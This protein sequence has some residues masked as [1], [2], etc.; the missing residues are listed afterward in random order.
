MTNYAKRESDLPGT[1]IVSS[2]LHK[3]L[4]D[5]FSTVSTAESHVYPSAALLGEFYGAI[6]LVGQNVSDAVDKSLVQTRKFLD[7]LA[8]TSISTMTH[9]SSMGSNLNDVDIKLRYLT[10]MFEA[11]AADNKTLLTE[12]KSLSTQVAKLTARLEEQETALS[13]SNKPQVDFTADTAE[14]KS[15]SGVL[16]ATETEIIPAIS[17][18]DPD[19]QPLIV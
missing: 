8:A 12:V 16:V 14:S 19:T 1:D 2:E 3:L 13:E 17:N 6:R 11:S 18:D 9:I 5:F 4:N 15:T 10:A 7:E